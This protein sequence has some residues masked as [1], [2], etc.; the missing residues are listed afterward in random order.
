VTT[1]HHGHLREALTATAYELARTDG[2]DGVV[3]REVARRTG[4]SHNAAYRHFADRDELL[5][6]VAGLA[7]DQLAQSMLTRIAAITV[8][9]PAQR[10]WLHLAETGRA[11]V[12]FA[13][14]EPGLF[15]LAFAGHE[16]ADHE[17]EPDPAA[18]GPY[19]VLGGV[20][21]ELVAAGEIAPAD[22]VG[23]D[24]YCWAAVHGFALLH[25]GG[26]LAAEPPA[27]RA[28]ALERLLVTIARGLGAPANPSTLQET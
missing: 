11:Y 26:P 5:S 3:L 19:D 14:A 8:G 16:P 10:A 17:G 27:A 1:Y 13:L 23:A 9:G 2:P 28:A 18:P 20:L 7:M 6:D 4:V 25:L 12:E 24:L 22:R 21:D 15:A